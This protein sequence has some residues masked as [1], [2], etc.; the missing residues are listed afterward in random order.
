[1]LT[2]AYRA[3]VPK[4]ITEKGVDVAR[5]AREA[6]TTATGFLQGLVSLSA[7][8]RQ[9]RSVSG[10]A[11]RIIPAMAEKDICRLMLAQLKGFTSRIRASAKARDVMPSFSLRKTGAIRR[12]DCMIPARTAEG[13]APVIRTKNHTSIS[14]ATEEAGLAPKS[15]CITP[16]RKAICIPETATTCISPAP[17]MEA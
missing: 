4:W 16:T 12:T 5:T 2:G 6:A 15:S 1:M 7:R 10:S 11:R 13:V 9:N 8:A 14:P 17:P 3:K